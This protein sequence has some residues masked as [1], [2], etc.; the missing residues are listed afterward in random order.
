MLPS[1]HA[2]PHSHSADAQA[3]AASER[4]AVRMLIGFAIIVAMTVALWAVAQIAN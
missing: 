3:L 1:E 4:L 2:H